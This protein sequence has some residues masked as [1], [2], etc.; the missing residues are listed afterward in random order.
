MRT[1]D[2]AKIVLRQETPHDEEAISDLY[3]AAF[4]RD[5]EAELVQALR[6][7]DGFQKKLSIVSTYQQLLV[8]HILF[9][10][11]TVNADKSIRLTALSP[12]A[13]LPN[14]QKQGIG[15]ELIR[16]GITHCRAL[17]YDA[18]LVLGESTYFKRFGFQHECVQ[19]IQSQYQC[20]YFLGLELT[21]GAL[22]D[23]QSITYPKPFDK[24]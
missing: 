24:I 14:Y 17:N 4:N 5:N 15:S 8:G 22:G 2:F 11:L 21:T 16:K 23:C 10:E 1:F 3:W 20:D 7:L 13:V 18:I 6:N 9:T 12:M 19:Q